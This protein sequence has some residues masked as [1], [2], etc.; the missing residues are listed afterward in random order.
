[1]GDSLDRP[2]P[3]G[4]EFLSY[5][6]F[7]SYWVRLRSIH[8]PTQADPH[9]RTFMNGLDKRIGVALGTP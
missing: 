7:T 3:P 6:L 4:P 9:H 8:S 5:L 1:M 2:Y